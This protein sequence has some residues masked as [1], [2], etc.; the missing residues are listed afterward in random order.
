[1]EKLLVSTQELA[2]HIADEDWLVLD[3]RHDL[4]KPTYG[5]DAYATAH[6]PGAA[7]VSIDDDLSGTKTG[8]N[9]RHPL[10]SREAAA[11]MFGA[12]GVNNNT[13]VVC[14]DDMSHNYSVRAWW[15]LRWLGHAR[16]VLLDG[17]INKWI[18]EGRALE[19]TIA[20]RSTQPF[21]LRPELTHAVDLA[22]ME[23]NLTS[24]EAQIIDARPLER[25]RGEVE[26]I[27]PVPGHIPGAMSRPWKSNLQADGTFKS[28]AQLRSEFESI[29]MQAEHI[30]HQ[31]GSGV[32]ACHNVFAM[33]LAGLIGSRLYAG[34]YSEWVSEH[35]SATPRPIATGP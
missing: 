27:D 1:M 33:Q 5:R 25:F 22:F 13:M 35:A 12:L 32:T 28:A 23:R 8:K 29:P 6:I 4:M 34:S 11:A 2:A 14:Y 19:Q 7:F 30:V 18:A 16:V 9:G 17:G 26:P 10:P 3:T 15:M 20:T 24:K 31:C 21:A